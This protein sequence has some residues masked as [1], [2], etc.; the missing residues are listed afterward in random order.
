VQ[1]QGNTEKKATTM[2]MNSMMNQPSGSSTSSSTQQQPQQQQQ[3]QPQQQQ[4]QHLMMETIEQVGNGSIGNQTNGVVQRRDPVPIAPAQNMARNNVAS[5]GNNGLAPIV[6]GGQQRITLGNLHFQQDP[7]DPQKW[8]ITNEGP[9]TVPSVQARQNQSH[10]RIQQ[11]INDDSM[12][13]NMSS[14]Y[15]MNHSQLGEAPK[16]CACTCLNCQQN[17]R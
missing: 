2:V 7:N 6:S 12:G 16:R 15:D 4:Q 1:V 3:Q 14:E 8:I 10:Q 9:P 13:M 17:N 5:S 11:S